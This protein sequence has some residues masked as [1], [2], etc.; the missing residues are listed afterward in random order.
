MTNKTSIAAEH[1]VSVILFLLKQWV[2]LRLRLGLLF[3]R[4]WWC[5]LDDRQKLYATVLVVSNKNLAM[6]HHR[7]QVIVSHSRPLG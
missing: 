1:D 7:M 3:W 4:W 6:T 2:N 5:C